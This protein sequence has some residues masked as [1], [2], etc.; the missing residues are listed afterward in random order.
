M[1]EPVYVSIQIIVEFVI[2]LDTGT[3]NEFILFEF[4]R[5]EEK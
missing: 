4:N 2:Y 3:D 1:M 5:L